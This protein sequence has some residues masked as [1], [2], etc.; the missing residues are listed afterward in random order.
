MKHFFWIRSLLENIRSRYGNPLGSFEK[1]TCTKYVC[2]SHLSNWITTKAQ[3]CHH[4]V[5]LTP[6]AAQKH[7][8]N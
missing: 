4:C 7:H 5:F 3:N 2:S 8:W 1:K 6:L